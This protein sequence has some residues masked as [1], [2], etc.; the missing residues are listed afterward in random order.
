ML[1]GP[2]RVIDRSSD[3]SMKA[4][5]VNVDL[6]K[7]RR[8]LTKCTDIAVLYTVFQRKGRL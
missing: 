1:D 3:P 7:R 6:Q 8:R 5:Q 2:G 4:V